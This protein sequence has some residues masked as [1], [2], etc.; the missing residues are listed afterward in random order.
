[1]TSPF[2]RHSSSLRTS[3][4]VIP[5]AAA[6]ASGPDSSVA[7]TLEH[8]PGK[9]PQELGLGPH[10]AFGEPQVHPDGGFADHLLHED[11]GAEGCI[12]SGTGIV[13]G[14]GVSGTAPMDALSGDHAP[15]GRMPFAPPSTPEAVEEQHS[16]APGYDE[17]ADGALDEYGS[18]PA[19]DEDGLP[20]A[21]W[22]LIGPVGLVLV[23]ATFWL[24]RSRKQATDD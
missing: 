1:M 5:L 7:L 3:A 6:S 23:A 12:N 18:G 22:A 13:A 21:G 16:D 9:G 19:Y 10:H 24:E 11:L 14:A 4:T 2:C 15:Q 17:T 20:I 8:F